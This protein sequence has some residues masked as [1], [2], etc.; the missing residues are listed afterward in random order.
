MC[1][2]KVGIS[3]T[4]GTLGI[5]VLFAKDD[6]QCSVGCVFEDWERMASVLFR[7]DGVGDGDG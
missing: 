3:E 5:P 6:G 2:G 7:C 1:G 4:G